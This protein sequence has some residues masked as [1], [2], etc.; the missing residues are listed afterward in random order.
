MTT[1]C[2]GFVIDARGEK[3]TKNGQRMDATANLIAEEQ[4]ND[5]AVKENEKGAQ[6]RLGT[7]NGGNEA[8]SDGPSCAADAEKRIQR[9]ARFAGRQREK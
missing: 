2:D 7:R 1:Q 5:N 6:R 3:R 9:R 8:R 4:K